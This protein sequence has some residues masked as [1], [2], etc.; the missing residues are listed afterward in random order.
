MERAKYTDEDAARQDLGQLQSKPAWL[1]SQH[2]LPFQFLSADEFEIFC[3]LLLCREHPGENIFYY[4]KTG[5]AGRDIVHIKQ[6]GSVELIQCKRYQSNVGLPEIRTEFAKLYVNL[7]NQVI[8]ERP[9]QVTFYVVPDLTAQAQ[10]L[11]SQPS[12]WIKIAEL[13]LK[14]HL[15]TQP[16]QALLNFALTWHPRFFKQTG[17]DLTQR[18]LKHEDLLEEFF[19]YKKIIDSDS[20][21]INAIIEQG[22][23]T[24]SQ[25][26]AI[27][28]LLKQQAILLHPNIANVS[29]AMRDLL[30]KAE[31]ENSGIVFSA[32]VDSQTQATVIIV[33]A[34]AEPVS[35]GTL[36]F[37]NTEAG[38]R[39]KQKFFQMAIEEGRAIKLEVGEF[40]WKWD[41]KLPEMG[42]A[43]LKLEALC[44]CP[45]L[46]KICIPIRLDILQDKVS[47]SSINFTYLH[48]VR[49]G[50]REMEFLVEGGQ[51]IGK[52]TLISYLQ[53]EKITLNL[54]D[55]DLCFM[56]A[57]QARNIMGIM[58]ALHQ[59][60]RLQVTSLEDDSVLFNETGSVSHCNM[61]KEELNIV[62]NFLDCLVK[63]ND[64]FGLALQYPTTL[65][66]E[67]LETAELIVT[68]IE[69]GK[70][71]SSSG[72][73][74]LTYGRQDALKI[75]E[76][77]RTGGGNLCM[78]SENNY[79]FLSHDLPM[80]KSTIAFK[81][82]FP[83]DDLSVLEQA[84]ERLSESD[85]IR[86]GLQYECMTETFLR[87]L[88]ES[89][90]GHS[91][92]ST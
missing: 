66:S 11:I 48:L 38:E 35:F 51:L 58:F 12:T 88:P 14:E 24:Q 21:K 69:K 6:D 23:T 81:N 78:E 67:M 15:K 19:A 49:A 7:H 30:S 54:G 61:S 65:D 68:A 42:T 37:P 2:S 59:G 74:Y 26:N 63:I 13:A 8:A 34:K 20:P 39:G 18:A 53:D 79:Q 32:T 70:M 72:T 36:V 28:Q 83:V 90:N 5:D 57:A 40:D 85:S 91:S 84:V 41:F 71:D 17:I 76:I 55:I 50:T 64:K 62:N 82:I 22:E 31:E 16:T 92:T 47:I 10:D 89:T 52:I 33:K 4:G 75:I 80:G 43:P 3:Y 56:T 1:E 73:I 29:T 77:L 46:P 45:R 87:W 86:L 60:G 25:L 27:T 9:E 44:F